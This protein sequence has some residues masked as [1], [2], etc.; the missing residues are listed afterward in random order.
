MLRKFLVIRSVGRFEEYK[1]GGD[2]EFRKFNLIYAENGRGKTT[3]S[4]II[5]SLATG[6][7]TYI[8]QRNTLST[9]DD[10]YVQV[11]LDTGKATL[12][13]GQWDNTFPNVEIFDSTYVNENVFSGHYVDLDHRRNL[14]LFVIG[15]KGVKLSQ[16]IYKL[17]DE[18]KQCNAEIN[19]KKSDIQMVIT[20]DLSV[21]NFA[22]LSQVPDI[23]QQIEAKQREIDALE[24]S[25]EIIAKALLSKVSLPSNNNAELS[26]LLSKQLENV[27]TAAMQHVYQHIKELGG[28]SE[29]W[30]SEGVTLQQNETCPFCGQSTSGVE[31]VL[32]YQSFFSRAY[33]DLKNEVARYI[34]RV[35]SAFSERDLLSLTNTITN[36]DELAGYWSNFLNEEFPKLD[37]ASIQKIWNE[38]LAGLKTLLEHKKSMPLEPV[39]TGADFERLVA[40]YAAAVSL[41][42][43][44]NRNI[45][46]INQRV[47]KLKT[48][49]LSGDLANE[50]LALKRLQDIRKRFEEKVA[51]TCEAYLAANNKKRLLE[52]QKDQAKADLKQ[53]TETILGDYET[54]LNK[55][56]ERFGASFRI[57]EKK[58]PSFSGGKPSVDYEIVLDGKTMA[59][60]KPDAHGGDPTF[61]SLLSDGDKNALAFALFM[62]RLEAMESVELADKV[63]IF[64]DPISSLDSFRKEATRQSILSI[65]G[66]AKQVI[67]LSHDPYYLRMAWENCDRAGT[68]VL[69]I[70]RSGNQSQII[71]WDV[72]QETRGDYFNN[73]FV[74]TE[75]LDGSSS[76]TTE[77]RHVARCIRPLLEANL[78]VRFPRTFKRGEWLGDFI[79]KIRDA[80]PPNELFA[81]QPL[82]SEL[83][84]VNDYSKKYHHSQNPSADSETISDTEL[85]T[86]IKR[87]LDLISGILV[88]AK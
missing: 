52:R 27:S 42:E 63:I 16:T 28:K 8:A 84:E 26:T 32:A 37:I 22:N 60:G 35:S 66:K 4:H 50:K 82:L 86:Y 25:K 29:T 70:A 74:L 76:S 67:V 58:Q 38:Y 87:T 79:E 9:N 31:L 34:D 64:D 3:L 80:Q 47:E 39:I 10:P 83:T 48:G 71:E 24:K 65:S 33:A 21:D 20:S 30:L 54:I 51:E 43:T 7:T 56:L 41:V 40:D 49:M 2:V 14:Y 59:L 81:L 55:Y 61:H 18:I 17:D 13:S 11:L 78:R 45:T 5:R 75:Y 57:Q 12:K 23:E 73:Y 6:D 77:M 62:A 85:Q 72:E 68:K 69:Q 36:N 44:Y 15:E 88:V 19:D 53:Y 46:I 1:P